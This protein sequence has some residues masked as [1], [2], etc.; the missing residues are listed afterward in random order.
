MTSQTQ[1][2]CSLRVLGMLAY[3]RQFQPKPSAVRAER[4]RYQDGR[5]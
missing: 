2:F 5:V 3:Y 4:R 1:E